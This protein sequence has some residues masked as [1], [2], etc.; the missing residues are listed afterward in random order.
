ME[1]K[2]LNQNRKTKKRIVIVILLLIILVLISSPF[3]IINIVNNNNNKQVSEFKNNIETI[4][5]DDVSYA[6]LEINPKVKL[7]IIDNKITNKECLNEDCE[8]IFNNVD[9]TGKNIKEVI[10][11]FYNTSKDNGINV[12]MGVEVLITDEK[13]KEEIFS[14]GYAHYNYVTSKDIKEYLNGKEI[15]NVK[16]DNEEILKTLKKDSDYGK[17]FICSNDDI[18]SCYITE[19]FEKEMASANSMSQFF[20]TAP[21]LVKL[22]EKFNIEYTYSDYYGFINVSEIDTLKGYYRIGTNYTKSESYIVK[23]GDPVPEG[24]EEVFENTFLEVI[25]NQ[26]LLPFIKFDLYNKTFDEKDLFY[27]SF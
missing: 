13:M 11:L 5:K 27:F 17:L 15:E 8:R 20:I 12:T 16:S 25:P 7:E 4:T 10:E 23:E 1:N 24:K 22:L 2:E 9:V 19:E 14:I 18:I 3:V 6:I 21:K 26:A